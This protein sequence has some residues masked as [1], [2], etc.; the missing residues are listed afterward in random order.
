[1]KAPS[2]RALLRLTDV[3]KSFGGIRALYDLNC[4][5]PQGRIT[6]VIGPNGAGKTTLFNVITGAYRADTGE[7]S[8]QGEPITA[9]PRDARRVSARDQVSW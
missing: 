8:F 5:V 2:D 7:V 4:E 6:G 1:M 9:S 3:S